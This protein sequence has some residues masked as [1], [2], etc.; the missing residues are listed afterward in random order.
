MP[1]SETPAA[2]AISFDN[3]RLVGGLAAFAIAVATRTIM[4]TIV[5]GMLAMTA[6]RL[7]T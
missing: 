5:G 4:L 6:V 7:L 2:W 3:P 1:R